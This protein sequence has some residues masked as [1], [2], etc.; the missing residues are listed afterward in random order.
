V[1]ALLASGTARAALAVARSSRELADED[2]ARRVEERFFRLVRIHRA[3]AEAA[4]IA[5]EAIASA[6]RT[7]ACRAIALRLRGVFDH[8]GGRPSPATRS[9]RASI[10]LFS[11]LGRHLDAGDVSR[12][13]VDVRA[14]AG[15]DAGSLAAARDARRH[16]AR[17]GGAD[18]KRLGSLAM[19]LGNLHHRRD[20]HAEALRSYREAARHFRKA[21]EPLRLANV[22]Y[23]RANILASLDRVG[24][25]R[26]LYESARDAFRGAGLRALEA[27]ADYA[28][29]GLDLV[30]GRLDACVRRLDRVRAR[31][32]EMRDRLAVAHTDLETA[33]AYLRLNR[34]G[35][36]EDA[37]RKAASFF[38]RA[39]HD[40]EQLTSA[41]LL[42]GAAL[43]RGLASRAAASFA[44][45]RDL[46]RRARNPVAVALAEIGLAQAQARAGRPR[47]AIEAAKRAAAVLR[48]RGLGSREARALAVG[49]DAALRA[50]RVPLART[51]AAR[52]AALAARRGDTRVRFAALLVLG[53]VE[54]RAGDRERAFRRLV[55]AERCVERLR[56]GITTEESRLA[57]ALDKSEVYEA[58]I[59]NRLAGKDARSIRQALEYAERGKARALAERLAGGRFEGIGRGSPA[60]RKALERL[61][62]IERELALAES[63]LEE[64][65][66]SPGV[67]SARVSRLSGLTA[68]RTRVLR[69]LSRTD[70]AGASLHGAPPPSPWDGVAALGHD[71]VVLEYAESDGHFHLF[72]IDRSG[73]EAWPRICSVESARSL[74]DMLRFQLG[75]GILGEDHASRFGGLIE[76]TIRGYLERLHD[77]LL[78]PV[79]DGIEG[80]NVRIVPH[81]LLHGLPFHALESGGVPLIE[82]S[83][84]SYAPSLG[85]L[86]LL[87]RPASASGAPPM[88]LG[89]P[90][91]AAPAIEA[92]V[93]AVRR[94]VRGAQVFRGSAATT[95]AIRRSEDRPSLLHVACHGF[96]GE[97]GSWS[98]GLRLG[99]AWLSLP[100]IY[101]LR[102][103]ADLVVLSGCETGRG[104]VYSGDEWVGLVRGFLQ[105]GARS[106][107]ASLWEV[108]DRSAVTLMESF[109]TFLA[110]GVPVGRA[111][112]EAQRAARRRD[113]LPIRWAPFLLIGQP[114]LTLP[115]RQVA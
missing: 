5:A 56:R 14:L 113:S 83:L 96:F 99:D 84:V 73:V 29:A 38:A 69:Q 42:G 67:R 53:R 35:D 100:E 102:G 25:A 112:A 47:P 107:V 49:A 7:P 12:A 24:E 79:A 52:A 87:A 114:D 4:V 111:L 59:T 64:A 17:G 37:A 104:T 93:D 16:Y 62:D 98:G 36:A 3:R 54:E 22:A 109:Y 65:E 110:S 89:V 74:V 70:P 26:R 95:E 58:L 57:F 30:E 18:P 8:L 11:D 1:R 101:T 105:A 92:E 19:N 103:T 72:R 61:R 94:L 45:A 63:R 80:K 106:V 50:G 41:S 32:E 71:E 27:Q 66:G 28:L 9:L 10:R 77:R 78:A 85:V 23:N 68:A 86:G 88:V 33:E 13:L 44:R 20:R 39:G 6:T 55:E 51:W 31:Q 75:K 97:E 43:Q 21:G 90:D 115:L 48:R 46:G 34:A 60:A 108:H 15:D 91:R 76:T 2:A 40:A 81:G 82:R